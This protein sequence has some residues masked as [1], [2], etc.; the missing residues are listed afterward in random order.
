M[1]ETTTRP[2]TADSVNL[3]DILK[4]HNREILIERS[5]SNTPHHSIL[6]YTKN[7]LENYID[8]CL[9]GQKEVSK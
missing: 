9:E 1:I 8:R 3:D 6:V 2:K 7:Q 5:D 4:I